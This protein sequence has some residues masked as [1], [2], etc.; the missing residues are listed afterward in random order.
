[1]EKLKKIVDEI[2]DPKIEDPE[3]QTFG[4]DVYKIWLKR[5]H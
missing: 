4:A 5:T 1:M 3:Y 2:Y